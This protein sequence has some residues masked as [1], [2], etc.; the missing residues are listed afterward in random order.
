MSTRNTIWQRP[1]TVRYASIHL[2]NEMTEGG[3]I[4]LEVIRGPFVLRLRLPEP[5]LTI[6]GRVRAGK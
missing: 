6:M 3:A 1:E 4:Y 5:L 2:Y